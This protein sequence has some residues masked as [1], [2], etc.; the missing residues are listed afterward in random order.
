MVLRR[1]KHRGKWIAVLAL[2]VAPLFLSGCFLEDIIG[3]LVNELP[4]AVIDASPKEGTA[5]LQVTFDG[6]YSRDDGTIV[7]YRWS[8]GDPMSTQSAMACAT[9]HTFDYPGTYLVKLTV[10]DDEGAV[11]THQVAIVV[12]D[13]PPVA[14]ASVSNESPLPGKTVIFNASASY[15]FHGEIVAYHWEFGDGE[16]ATGVTAEHAYSKGGYYVATLTVTDDAGEMSQT[17]IGISV[18]PGENSCG[19][20]GSCGDVKPLAIITSKYFSCS[21]GGSV[22]DVITLDGS[23]SRGAVGNIVSYHWDFGD[24][25]TGSGASVTHIYDR[26]WTYIITLTVADE[27]GLTD[28][29]TGTLSIGGSCS[30]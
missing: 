6:Q 8:F 10:I 4:H 25:T 29:A 7:E 30:E 18:L 13:P 26:A 21:A 2:I 14:Q 22:G 28:T 12:T 9:T 15:D 17:H 3:S 16:T 23:A 27:G 20:D 5:P 24:G 11:D 19:N 1:M